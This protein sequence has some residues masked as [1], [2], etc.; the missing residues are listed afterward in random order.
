MSEY[1]HYEWLQRCAEHALKSSNELQGILAGAALFD[2]NGMFSSF[3]R[4]KMMRGRRT[5]IHAERDAISQ[6]EDAACDGTL[7]TTLEPCYGGEKIYLFSSCAEYIVRV[8]IA[9]VIIGARDTNPDNTG[10][11]YLSYRGIKCTLDTS[12]EEELNEKLRYARRSVEIGKN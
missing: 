3:G 6:D 5:I 9:H 2:K 10:L 1:T 8:G 11:E 7:I 12:Y 4:R